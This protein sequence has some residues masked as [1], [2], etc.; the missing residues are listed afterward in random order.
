MRPN[1]AAPFGDFRDDLA[2]CGDVQIRDDDPRARIGKRPSGRTAN[3]ARSARHDRDGA[4]D[5]HP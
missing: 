5:S 1:F 3:A 4:I 2:G